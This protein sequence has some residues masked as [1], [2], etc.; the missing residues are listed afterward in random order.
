M[1]Q[2]ESPVESQCVRGEEVGVGVDVGVDAAGGEEVGAGVDVGVD[3]AAGGEGW[4]HDPFLERDPSS[5]DIQLFPDHKVWEMRDGAPV[6]L[7][8]TARTVGLG[9]SQVKLT[10]A[11]HQATI[12]MISFQNR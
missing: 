12:Y 9:S 7:L 6:R 11:L 3:A 8:G 2:C 5:I 10:C 1:Q 4:V